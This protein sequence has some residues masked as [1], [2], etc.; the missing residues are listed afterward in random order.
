[1]PSPCIPASILDTDLYKLTMQQ[2]VLQT[3]PDVAAT[4]KFTMR[5]KDIRFNEHFVDLLRQSIAHFH[6]LSL[7]PEELKWLE[8]NCKFFSHEYLA[9]LSQYRFKPEQVVVTFIPSEE[10]PALGSID[11]D[12]TG[13]WVECILWEIPILA[14]VSELYFTH[15]DVDWNYDKQSELAY[16][17][18]KRL[19]H[20]GCSFMEFGTRR[21]RTGRT[22]EIVIQ[23]LIAAS[24]EVPG[25]GKLLGTSNVHYAQKYNLAP[26]GTV[27]HEWFMGV[28][29]LKGYENSNNL[30]LDYWEKIYAGKSTLIA[31]TDTFSTKA[32]FESLGKDVERARRWPGLRQDS[33]DP[34]E[35]IKQ[36]RKA[37][38]D[39][40]IDHRQKFITFSDSLNIDK[41][42]ELQKSALDAGFACSFGI[43][44]NFTND[45]TKATSTDEKSKALN[46]VIKL[47]YVNGIECVKISDDLTKNTGDEETVRA[48]KKIFGLPF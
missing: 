35:F 26:M 27:A 40:G 1:M 19:L 32:F 29:A 25:K 34:F 36:A 38:Q 18:A 10:N 4:Y 47:R 17:K 3:F 31:L 2:A 48:V 46:M 30:A 16:D 8:S 43:G 28:A 41:A 23:A 37:Y 21:R 15:I 6:D 9:F 24:K 20:N 44:T 42:L 13:P 7:Q 12:M 33:G 22:Q 39:M 5:D 14:I 11:I 45:F